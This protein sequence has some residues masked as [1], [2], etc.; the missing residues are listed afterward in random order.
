MFDEQMAICARGISLAN[1]CTA[2]PPGIMSIHYNPAGLSDL[3]VGK[4]LDLGL[5]LPIILMKI[6]LNADPNAKTFLDGSSPNATDPKKRDPLAGKE[7]T[8]GP[9]MYLPLY[10]DTIPF[11]A[12]PTVGLSTRESGSK[13]TFAIGSYVPFAAGFTHDKADDPLRYAAK[14]VVQQH[15]IYA[16]PSASYKAG[17]NLSLGFSIGMGQTATSVSMDMR[18]PSDMIALT[19]VLGDAT[20]GLEIPIVSELTLPSPWFGGGVAPYDKI[21]Q[22]SMSLRD[23]FSPSYNLGI[24]WKPKDW[25]AFGACYQSEIQIEQTGRYSV[26]HSPQFSAMMN[27]MRQGM[28]LPVA[29]SMLNLPT[30]GEDQYGYCT[31]TSFNFPQIIQAGIK[32]QPLNKLKFLFDL[33]WA[34]WSVLKEDRFIFDQPISLLRLVNIMGYGESPNQM[35]LK[36]NFKDTLSWSTAIEYLPTDWLTLRLG[37]ELRPTSVRAEL[38]DSLYALPD[39]HNIG[40]GFGIKLDN[41]IQFNLAFAYIFN[42]SYSVPNGSSVQMNSDDWTKPVYNPFVGLDYIQKTQIYIFS[43]N[44]SMPLDLFVQGTKTGI[45]AVTNIFSMLNPFK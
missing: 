42:N 5:T 34:Q 31:S 17:D 6:K 3:P 9:L 18:S 23:D 45:K 35:V 15:L 21:A 37:Y 16:A 2:D 43:A 10:N 13:W 1:T 20:H 11:L 29:A 19:K 38:Y 14:S 41:G 44:T 30:S 39:L 4:T 22:L 8:T 28:I 40:T 26:Q 36:R 12:A 32:L 25:F 33:H 27:W 24:L 7:G